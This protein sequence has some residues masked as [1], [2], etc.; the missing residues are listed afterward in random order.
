MVVIVISYTPDSQRAIPIPVFSS[1]FSW[2]RFLLMRNIFMLCAVF[3]MRC[4]AFLLV[5]FC[6]ILFHGL[7]LIQSAQNCSDEFVGDCQR[8]CFGCFIVCNEIDN[9]RMI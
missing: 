3:F 5:R 8:V 7:K 6:F 2:L 4:I 1:N 9:S